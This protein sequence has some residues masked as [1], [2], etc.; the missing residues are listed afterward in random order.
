MLESITTAFIFGWW[1]QGAQQQKDLKVTAGII[2]DLFLNGL[3][4]R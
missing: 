3:K 1:E 2:M 4:K